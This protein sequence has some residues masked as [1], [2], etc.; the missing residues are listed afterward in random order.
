[1]NYRKPSPISVVKISKQLEDKVCSELSELG[2]GET[3]LKISIRWDY[4][5]DGIYVH[6]EKA[7]KKYIIY[8]TGLDVVEFLI[9]ASKDNVLRPLRKIASGGEMSRIMLAFKKIIV[10][11][12][13]ISS[14]VFDEVDAGVGGKIADAVGRK[15]R[16]LSEN[17]QVIVITHLHQIAGIPGEE[18]FHFKVYKDTQE[19]TKIERLNQT[20]RIEEIAR[21]IGGEKINESAKEHARTLLSV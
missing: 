9:A 2:M 13:P 14:M 12:D 20:E 19:G 21:M 8:A 5:D 10:E 11:S 6:P 7:D 18:T 17:A 3:Q 15:L 4:G 16:Q 1:M